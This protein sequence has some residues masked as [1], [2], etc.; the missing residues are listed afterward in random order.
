MTSNGAVSH[1]FAAVPVRE[2]DADDAVESPG[3]G[4]GFVEH[5]VPDSGLVGSTG[6]HTL[7][8]PLGGVPREQKMLRGHLPR[9]MYHFSIRR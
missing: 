2:G 6:D 7:A 4:Q 9:V 5:V 1:L 3:S 8:G